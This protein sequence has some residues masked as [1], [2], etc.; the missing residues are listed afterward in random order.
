MI[1]LPQ[2]GSQASRKDNI[3]GESFTTAGGARAP[4]GHTRPIGWSSG[5]GYAIDRG[6]WNGPERTRGRCLIP[7]LPPGEGGV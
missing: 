6:P 1:R 4:C 2:V 7:P 3:A 5:S